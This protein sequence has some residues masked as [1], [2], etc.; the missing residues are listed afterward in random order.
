MSGPV[1]AGKRRLG[2]DAGEG[3]EA[4][5]DGE[6]DAGDEG[7]GRVVEEPQDGADEVGGMGAIAFTRTP[8]CEKWTASHWVKFDTPAFAAE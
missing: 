7:G 4:A 6:D 3:V 5:V 1:Q 2:L 8:A